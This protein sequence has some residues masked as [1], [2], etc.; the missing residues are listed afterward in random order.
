MEKS[1]WKA[2]ELKD[3]ALKCSEAIKKLGIELRKLYKKEFVTQRS[4]FHK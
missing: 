2:T 3:A 4:K 1:Q